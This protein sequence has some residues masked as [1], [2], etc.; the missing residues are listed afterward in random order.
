M[1]DLKQNRI[2][3]LTRASEYDRRVNETL[4]PVAQMTYRDLARQWRRLADRAVIK[5]P[6]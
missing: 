4:D 3:C 1:D 6:D 5:S 2:Y